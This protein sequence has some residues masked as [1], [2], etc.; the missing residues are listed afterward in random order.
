M[1]G[2]VYLVGAG[3]GNPGLITVRGK[4]VLGRAE[5]VVYDALAD[6][7]FLL[8]APPRAERVYV[9]KRA[10]DPGLGQAGI[11]ALLVERAREGKTVVRL[12][13]GDP[14]VFGRGAEECEA[15]ALAGIPY[16]VVPGVTSGIAAASYAGI[17]L[18]H[19]DLA[20]EV[21][22]ATAHRAAER[23]GSGLDCSRIAEARGTVVLFMGVSTLEATVNEIL[24]A[25]R[26]P[27]T[28]SAVVAS[29]TRSGQRVVAGPLRDLPTLAAA[30]GIRAPAVIILGEVVRLRDRLAWLEKRPLFGRSIVVTRARDRAGELSMQLEELGAEVIDAPTIEIAPPATYEPLDQAIAELSQYDWLVLTSANAVERFLDR[31][32]HSGWD[33]RALAGRKIAAVGSATAEALREAHLTPDAM[34]AEFNAEALSRVLSATGVAGKRFLFARAADGSEVLPEALRELGARVD[35]V[36]AYRTVRPALDVTPL[37]TRFAQ[38]SIDAVTFASSSAVKNFVD[39]FEPGEAVKRLAGIAIAV[40]GP[41]TARTV[42]EL[43]LTVAV[44]PAQATVPAMVE[45]LVAYFAHG[46]MR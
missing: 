17:P 30:A 27:A 10:D 40:I 35:V 18:T 20:S 38:G 15:L 6:D 28:P 23:D 31:L 19:R 34:P 5:V 16:E 22:F 9:G 24:S 14:F 42:V 26:D 33:A 41:V 8:M 1:P 7:R 29:A 45:A 36:P 25:G 43:G 44:R 12:K 13:G 37:R 2:C 39:H 11:N 21:L 3:P 4:E 46:R 32:R